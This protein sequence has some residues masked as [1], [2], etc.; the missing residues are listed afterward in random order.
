MSNRHHCNNLSRE[1]FLA[2]APRY[3]DDETHNKNIIVATD[4]ALKG[5]TALY[6][7]TGGKTRSELDAVGFK[8]RYSSSSSDHD[9]ITA[10]TLL[11]RPEYTGKLRKSFQRNVVRECTEHFFHTRVNKKEIDF[12]KHKLILTNKVNSWFEKKTRGAIKEMIDITNIIISDPMVMVT[13]TVFNGKWMHPFFTDSDVSPFFISNTTAIN[14]RMMTNTE[15][16]FT[17][18][19]HLEKDFAATIVKFPFSKGNGWFVAVMPNEPATADQLVSLLSRLGDLEEFFTSFTLKIPCQYESMPEFRGE[20]HLVLNDS[21]SEPLEGLGSIE[22]L[23]EFQRGGPNFSNMFRQEFLF[24]FLKLELKSVIE[25]M[26]A[27]ESRRKIRNGTIIDR[28]IILN[29]P[30][31]YFIINREN[32]VRCIGI[33][34]NPNQ[35]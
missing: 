32:Y 5:F 8:E 23:R 16:E 17:T 10:I 2:Y 31:L 19:S 30:M 26:S 25:T 13:K 1:L 34:T 20:T 33:L 28:K 3:L 18:V 6:H 7:G 35:L 27:T 9:D 4:A 12:L 11:S 21:L 22:A 24:T 15:S 14:A 29:K